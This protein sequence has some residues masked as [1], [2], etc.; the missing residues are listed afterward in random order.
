MATNGRVREVGTC[1]LSRAESQILSRPRM[2]L[3]LC[4]FTR[5]CANLTKDPIALMCAVS[6]TRTG[7]C[8]MRSFLAVQIFARF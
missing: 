6:R 5:D 2:R 7:Q 4:P 1:V 8:G 3:E